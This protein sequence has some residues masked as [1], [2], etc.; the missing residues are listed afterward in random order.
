MTKTEALRVLGLVR[1]NWGHR[2][3]YDR[4]T[5]AW[6]VEALAGA[7]FEHAMGAAKELALNGEGEPPTAGQLFILARR[8][9][10]QAT[11]FGMAV[12]RRM[13]P[14]APIGS[15]PVGAPGSPLL[16]S[17]IAKLT[18]RIGARVR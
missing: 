2:V 12:Q 13:I 4:V 3:P 6:W 1:A 15:D 18:A 11:E 8:R 9:Q 16:R 10:I 7:D 14:N 5:I 17:L